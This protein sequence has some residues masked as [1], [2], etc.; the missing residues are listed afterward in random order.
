ME[1]VLVT[2][3]E[4]EAASRASRAKDHSLAGCVPALL[5]ARQSIV[6]EVE[7]MRAL[8]NPVVRAWDLLTEAEASKLAPVTRDAWDRIVVAFVEA[9]S[10]HHTEL[11]VPSET[12]G[13]L[14]SRLVG[15]V[16][17]ELQAGFGTFSA[18]GQHERVER[19]EKAARFEDRI[20]SEWRGEDPKEAFAVTH[21][22]EWRDLP[23]ILSDDRLARL[24]ILS[25][26]S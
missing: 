12:P 2:L 3:A 7:T 4:I 17:I 6:D 5:Q 16:H 26:W 19:P 11:Y 18:Y 23:K 8:A 22:P 9:D 21:A 10:R 20:M 24:S 15:A 14:H 25:D 13:K 1:G